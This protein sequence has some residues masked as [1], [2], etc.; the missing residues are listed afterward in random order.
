MNPILSVVIATYNRKDLLQKQLIALSNQNIS[1]D[2]YEVIIVDDG[3]YDGTTELLERWTSD[4]KNMRFVSQQNQG[5][6]IAR[7]KGVS[8]AK[9]DFIAFTDDDCEVYHDWASHI[10]KT[11]QESTC[12]GIQG[13]TL[14]DKK[15]RTPL[16]HQIENETFRTLTPTC[17][18]AF[19]KDAFVKVG[20]F[21]AH[22]PNAHN[23]DVDLTWKINKLGIIRFEPKMKVF[24]PPILKSFLHQV[25]RM[26]MLK[27]EF[28]LF[29][30]HPE[31]YKKHRNSSPWKT[32]FFEVALFHQVRNL[33]SLVRFWKKPSVMLTGLALQFSSLIYLVALIPEFVMMSS[34]KRIYIQEK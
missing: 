34:K 4:H 27:S 24:H 9:A 5:P 13:A 32:I 21:S 16:T 12:V 8:L 15:A 31:D 14:T 6:A 18:A 2:H 33:K 25:K 19:R 3:S 17:N 30:L 20:G 11:F 10:I 28:I 23:E 7:N 26:R 29:K 22:F 1:S